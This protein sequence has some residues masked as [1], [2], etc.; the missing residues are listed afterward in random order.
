MDATELE[1]GIKDALMIKEEFKK[2]SGYYP[3][4]NDVLLLVMCI[5]NHKLQVIGQELA[6][7]SKTVERIGK[8]TFDNR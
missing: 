2:V 6:A 1:L 3:G 4:N 5:T 7:I 8:L